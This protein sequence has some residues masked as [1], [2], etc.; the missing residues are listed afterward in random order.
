MVLNHIQVTAT[1]PVTSLLYASEL[2]E[3][4]S[5]ACSEDKHTYAGCALQAHASLPDVLRD[6]PVNN[7]VSNAEWILI[8]LQLSAEYHHPVP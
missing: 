2:S 3:Y 1:L 5:P 7:E 4:H 8:P 6:C